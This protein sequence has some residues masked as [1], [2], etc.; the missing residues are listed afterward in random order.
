MSSRPRVVA[1]YEHHPHRFS[2]FQGSV[3]RETP[4]VVVRVE[5]TAGE[6]GAARHALSIAVADVLAQLNSTRPDTRVIV[7]GRDGAQ[8]GDQ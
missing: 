8:D 2:T 4:G 6:E 5:C 7:G 3:V 1:E